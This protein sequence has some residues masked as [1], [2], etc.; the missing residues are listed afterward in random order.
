M[1]VQPFSINVPQ[2]TLDD[3]HDRLAR[4]R[5]ATHRAEDDWTYGASSAYLHALIEHWRNRFDWRAQEQRLNRFHHFKA[6][7]DG[8]HVHFIHER[9]H[10]PRPLPLLLTHGF[11]DSFVRFLRI[12]PML[13]NPAAFGGDPTDAF[14]VVVPSLPGFGF[15]D[16]PAH[17]GYTFHIGDTLHRLMTEQ[18]RYTT[19]AA[20]GGD[21]GSTVTEQIARSYPRSIFGI[22]LTD[23]PFWHVFQKPEKLSRIERRFVDRNTTWQQTDGAYA[24]I[25]G[26]RPDTLAQSLIDSPAGLAAWIIDKFH[27]WSDCDDNLDTCFTKDELLTNVMVYWISGTI[28]TSFR[29]Y[30]DFANGGP[31]TWMFEGFKQ[32]IDCAPVPTAFAI[33]PKDM[34][35]P[36]RKWAERFFNVQRWTEMPR[37][38]HFGAMEQPDLLVED[39]RAFFRS[40]RPS[41]DEHAAHAFARQNV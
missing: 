31:V 23:V 3:L 18:L 40:F 37:G 10:G 24:F 34:S 29:P 21:W 26:H 7:V 36:P 38:G 20:H 16:A 41:D 15:S 22:H 2:T 39:L 6:E 14:D 1:S 9:G 32:W 25:Q 17:P 13:T 27:A 8:I 12:V 28:G 4:T 5:W 30:Y 11:P 19:Y 33:F 35:H